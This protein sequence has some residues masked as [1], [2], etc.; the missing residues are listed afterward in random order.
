MEPRWLTE[1]RKYIGQKEYPGKKHNAFV[2]RLWK[3]IRMPYTDD[4]TPWCAGFVGGCLE[5]CKIVSTRSAWARSYLSWKYGRKIVKP[6]LGCIVVFERGPTSGH[7]GYLVGYDRAGNLMIL[8]GN[9]R[10][11]VTIAPFQKRR[12]LAYFWPL[13]EKDCADKLPILKSNGELS[14]NEA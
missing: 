2:L 11:A 4:E 6:M 12:V 13:G 3:L 14:T 7:V 10:N 8:G 1:A 9:Q 5:L